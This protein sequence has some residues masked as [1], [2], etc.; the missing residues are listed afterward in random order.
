[1]PGSQAVDRLTSEVDPSGRVTACTYVQKLV[2]APEG[3]HAPRRILRYPD[4]C[5][6]SSSQ[7]VQKLRQEALETHHEIGDLMARST[8]KITSSVSVDS[9]AG[10]D[11]RRDPVWASGS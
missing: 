10:I 6:R 7:S 9:K 8:A 5:A 2:V 4:Q 11:D 1:M 3:G